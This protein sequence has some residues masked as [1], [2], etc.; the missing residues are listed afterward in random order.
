MEKRIHFFSFFFPFERKMTDKLPPNLLKLFAPRPPLPYYPPLDKDPQK[1][2]GC[3]VTGIASHVPELRNH[4]L[5]YVPWKSLAEK[6]KEK[7]YR[8]ICVY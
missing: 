5:D 1:R 6:R 8:V 2:V 4:D 7:V 3:I